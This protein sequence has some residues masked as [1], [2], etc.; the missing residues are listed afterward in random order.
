VAVDN[1]NSL[2]KIKKGKI[3]IIENELKVRDQDNQKMSSEKRKIKEVE[4][5]EEEVK[6]TGDRIDLLVVLDI[7]MMGKIEID[8]TVVDLNLKIKMRDSKEEY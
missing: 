6:A 3:M 2:I 4:E 8:S 7:R 5:E 1:K